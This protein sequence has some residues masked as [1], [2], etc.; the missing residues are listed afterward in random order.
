MI[1]FF[2]YLSLT[3]KRSFLISS[4]G[5]IPFKQF[6]LGALQAWK[7]EPAMQNNECHYLHNC[8]SWET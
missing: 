8:N 5:T 4:V 7:Q 3:Y 6:K 1:F 2:Q